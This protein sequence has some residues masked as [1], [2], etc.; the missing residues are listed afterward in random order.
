MEQPIQIVFDSLDASPA[1]EQQIKEK[2]TKLERFF[3]HMT[4]AKVIV[5]KNHKHH[6]KGNEF[7]VTIEVN[8][9]GKKLV[10]SKAPGTHERHEELLPTLN[11]AFNAMARQLEEYARKLRGEIKHHEMPPQG[12]I[13]KLLPEEGYGFIS[14]TDGREIYFH[15]NSV[16]GEGF[17]A[18]TEGC[19]VR[20][21]VDSEESDQGPQASTVE[22]TGELKFVDE[23][24]RQ[25]SGR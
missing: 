3:R 14:M 9:P 13:S 17:D 24:E 19:A 6:V 20:V 5:S 18:L 22:A 21:V 2:S 4:D 8:V 1:M 7:H 15:R 25:G 12:R 23:P 16:I 10:V 11:D